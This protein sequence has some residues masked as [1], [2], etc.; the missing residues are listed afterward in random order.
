MNGG[1]FVSKILKKYH[2]MSAPVKA[3]LWFMISNVIQKGISVLCTPIFTRMMTTEQYGEYSVYLSWYLIISIV[4]S[5]NLSAGVYN[6]ALTDNEK[7]SNKLSSAFLGLS[8]TITIIVLAIYI[9]GMKFWNSIFHMPTVLIIAMFVQSF[10]SSAYSLWA[11]KQRYNYKYR[12]IVITCLVIGLCGPI[13]AFLSVSVTENKSF[14]MILSFV[15]VQVAVGLVLYVLIIFEGKCFFDKCYW[16]YAL[17]FNLPLIPHYLSQIILNQADRIMINSLVGATATAMY[18][19]AYTISMVMLIVVSAINNTLVPYIYKSMKNNRLQQLKKVTTLLTIFIFGACILAILC[20][21]ELIRILAAPE[22]YDARWII[23]PVALS[24]L[25]IFIAGLFGTV[26]FFFQETK[27]VMIASSIAAVSNIILNYIFI[28]IFGYVAAGYTTLVCYFI[29][30]VAHYLFYRKISIVHHIDG[31]IY[32]ERGILILSLFSVPTMFICICIYN[33]FIIRYM[34]LV[35]GLGV[36][37]VKRS[38][39]ITAIK[40][41]EGD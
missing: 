4:T 40:N 37:F 38:K 32:N 18:S 36:V 23:P 2:N 16:K 7:D 34:L 20:G 17:V 6:N 29:L 25:F 35:V 10:F 26:E 22:Y 5:L 27:F 1:P 30:M 41:V 28:K 9:V 12:G 19:V 24:L 15:V 8:S 14:A 13:L 31:T 33:Y 39:I 3:S 11:A 21:P